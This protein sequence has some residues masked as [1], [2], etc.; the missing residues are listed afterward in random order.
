VLEYRVN[1]TPDTQY[2]RFLRKNAVLLYHHRALPYT[3]SVILHR[4]FK[5]MLHPA[6][7]FP[8]LRTSITS[9]A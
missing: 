4:R 1:L 8:W 7:L 6:A 9:T 5:Y 2:L 3:G